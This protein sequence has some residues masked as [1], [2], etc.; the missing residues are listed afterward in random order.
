M[1]K[2]W[3]LAVVFLCFGTFAVGQVADGKLQIHHI[4]VGQG[5][6]T[7]LV[8]P[9]GQVVL[10]DMGEDLRKK[11]C[12]GAIDYLDQ[13]G[14][15]QIDYIFVS[16][17]HFDHIGCIPAV[18]KE[19]PLVHFAYDR[20]ESYPGATFISYK[21]A[22]GKKRKTATLG[23]DLVLD[24]GSANPVKLHVLALD[25][26]TTSGQVKTANEND[27]SVSVLVEF[28]GFR[29]E[30]GGDLSGDNTDMYEDIETPEAK[31]VGEIDVYKVHHHCS[32]HSTNYTWLQA[33]RPTIAVIS[34]GVGN[35]YGHPAADCLARLHEADL[36]KVY[37][38][39]AG[40]GGT[41]V[42]GIDVISGDLTIEVAPAAKTYEVSY[43]GAAPVTYSVKSAASPDK[44]D[45]NTPAPAPK[46]AWSIKS[47]Y[48]HDANCPAVK[49]ISSANLQTGDTP[50]PDKRPSACVKGGS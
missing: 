38:T 14:V 49:R 22:L 42:A 47:E 9:G 3:V 46:Y 4:D 16:H 17:Y 10:F 48:Y 50:P 7:V 23:Q 30:I 33:A 25:G 15:R 44:D 21:K 43:K 35:D 8:S 39:E 11:D 20:G 24:S 41:P 36:E 37:W 6:G 1:F 45:D 13:M 31:D 5:D 32:S 34:T 19:F 26:K 2:R 27:L 29:E 18:L 12:Q 28:G 40:A